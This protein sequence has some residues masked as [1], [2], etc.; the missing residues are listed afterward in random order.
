VKI[1]SLGYRTDLMLLRLAGSQVTDR[2]EYVVIRTPANPTFWWGNFVLFRTSFAPGELAARLDI[3]H[4]ELPSADHVAL[5]IDTTDDLPAA[6]DEL[7]EAGISIER[8]TVMTASRVIAPGRPNDDATY[9]SL[10]GDDDWAQLLDLTVSCVEAQAPGDEE[11]IRRKHVAE[12]ALVE[13][14]HAVWFGAF[15]GDRLRAS[16]G[17]AAD[18]SGVARFQNV[19]THP[20]HRGRGLASTLV[21]RASTYGL[22]KLGAHTLVM[23]AD[24]EYLA[25]RLYRTLGFADTE[26][27]VQLSRPPSP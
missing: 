3:F 21:Y 1:T 22:T 14:G 20:A 24:P 12:R 10:D 8:N 4:S 17:L 9:R 6:E 5:G 16:L 27:Q 13:H 23:V 26:T 11:F 7:T 2:G 18:G 15:E 19:Q 25:I